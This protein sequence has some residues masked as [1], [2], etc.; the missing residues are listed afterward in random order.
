MNK[1]KKKNFKNGGEECGDYERR[2]TKSSSAP[3]KG[4]A[5]RSMAVFQYRNTVTCVR[6]YI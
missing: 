1:G 2:R 4:N 6:Q 3:G 5:D